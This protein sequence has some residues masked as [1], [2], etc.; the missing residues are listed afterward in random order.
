MPLRRPIALGSTATA[1]TLALVGPFTAAADS[2]HTRSRA[3]AVT[4]ASCPST[5]GAG[6]RAH[7]MPQAAAHRPAAREPAC[8]AERDGGAFPIDTRIDRGP[9][10]YHPGDGYRTWSIEL[11]NTTDVSCAN[12]HPILVLVDEGRQLKP[13]QIR[14][15]FSDGTRRRPV[16][17]EKTDR[18][19]YIGVFDDGFP[20]FSVGPGKTVTV[21]VRLGFT[22]DTRP[23]QV[24]GNAAVVQRHGDD[25]DW[26]GASNDYPFAI[27]AD[28]GASPSLTDE[29]AKTGPDSSLLGL[30]ATAGAFLLGGGALVAGSRRLRVDRR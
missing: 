27:D 7:R 12:I 19:E 10:T 30:G 26:V 5:A 17:F 2:G 13:R 9:T 14:L 3:C 16:P 4:E 24:V 15:D 18:D 6:T 25:G 29:L 28:G 22:P 20:G 11:T 8:D 1:V 21:E 23:G